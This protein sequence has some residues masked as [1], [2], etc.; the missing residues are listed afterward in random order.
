MEL[1]LITLGC[2]K[3]DEDC[4]ARSKATG[5]QV[6][7]QPLEQRVGGESGLERRGRAG[8]EVGAGQ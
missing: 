6:G 2:I 4:P 7:E 5:H 1:T 8:G 3:Q